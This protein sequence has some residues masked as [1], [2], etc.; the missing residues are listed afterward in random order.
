M[1]PSLENAKQ[2]LIDRQRTLMRRVP[3]KGHAWREASANAPLTRVE[4]REALEIEAALVRIGADRY[5]YCH[6]CSAPIGSIRLRAMPE[7]RFCIDCSR[8]T[9]ADL[10]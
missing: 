3:L 1:R 8:G 7:T 10:R 2:I 4:M 9:Q 6:W 5:G